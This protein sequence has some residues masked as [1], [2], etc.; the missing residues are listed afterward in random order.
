MGRSPFRRFSLQRRNTGVVDGADPTANKRVH[1]IRPCDRNGLSAYNVRLSA[2][3]PLWSST[4]GFSPSPEPDPTTAATAVS[5]WAIATPA[6][7]AR[8][9]P[10]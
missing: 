3:L 7:T 8:S 9:V 2:L 4:M 6:P 1:V 10:P 5:T